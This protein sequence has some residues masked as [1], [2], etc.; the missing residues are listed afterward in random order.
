MSGF[1]TM[2]QDLHGGG[3]CAAGREVAKEGSSGRRHLQNKQ[4]CAH[5]FGVLGSCLPEEIER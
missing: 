4:H 1:Q 2:G 3:R 5:R